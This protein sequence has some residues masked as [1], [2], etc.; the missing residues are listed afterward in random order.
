MCPDTYVLLLSSAR[1]IK[2]PK[3]DMVEIMI[4]MRLM[5]FVKKIEASPWEI[6][7]DILRCSSKAGPKIMASSIGKIGK[8]YL[9][10]K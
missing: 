5:G 2:G 4:K 10:M 9:F 6:I 7:N 8:S 1:R 3:K